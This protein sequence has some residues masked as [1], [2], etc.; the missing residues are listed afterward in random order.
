MLKN[1]KFLTLRLSE[2]SGFFFARCPEFDVG[3]FSN[4][5]KNARASLYNNIKTASYIL[6]AKKKQGEVIDDNLFNYASII[7]DNGSDVSQYFSEVAD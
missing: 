2:S 1:K 4:T 3:T 5:E 6:L 7:S